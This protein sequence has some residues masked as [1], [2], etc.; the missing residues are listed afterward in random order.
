[1]AESAVKKLHDSQQLDSFFHKVSK[2]LIAVPVVLVLIALVFRPA[3][4]SAPVQQTSGITLAPQQGVAVA[5]NVTIDIAKSYRCSQ[6]G[7]VATIKNKKIAMTRVA[8]SVATHLVFD[9]NCLYSWTGSAGSGSK[10]CGIGQFLNMVMLNQTTLNA[11][12]I[13]LAMATLGGKSMGI[14][15]DKAAINNFLATCQQDSTLNDQM[16]AV[17]KAVSFTETEL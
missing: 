3:S 15:V 2:Y 12:K 5:K 13:S 16:F 7:V 6:N 17:P 14:P 1:M 4:P 8:A 9:G 11:D 10:T